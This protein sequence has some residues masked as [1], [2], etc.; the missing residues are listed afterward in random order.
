MTNGQIKPRKP[1]RVD[2]ETFLMTLILIFMLIAGILI[3]YGAIDI[4]V[5]QKIYESCKEGCIQNNGYNYD[6][7]RGCNEL[8][9]NMARCAK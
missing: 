5:E 7:L 3:Y 6:C 1:R 9:E 4:P 2:L 8:L